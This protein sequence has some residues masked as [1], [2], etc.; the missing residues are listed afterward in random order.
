MYAVESLRFAARK[1]NQLGSD[2][3]QACSLK[4]GINLSNDIF[5]HCVWLDDGESAFDGHLFSLSVIFWSV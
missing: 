4:T 2:Y 3:F 1:V 5:R